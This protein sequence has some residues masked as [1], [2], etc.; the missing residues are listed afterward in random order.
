MTASPSLSIA[1][2]G[3]RLHGR[4]GLKWEYVRPSVCDRV[5]PPS[6]AAWIEISNLVGGSCAVTSPPSRAAWIEIQTLQ[7]RLWSYASPPSR[8]AWIEMKVCRSSAH[9][10]K[11]RRLH[12]RRGLKWQ[13]R[14]LQGLRA[15]GRR[16]HGRRGLK[17]LLPV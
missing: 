3:R 2:T 15:N 14:P 13:L 16:L 8:A 7:R 11:S 1:R 5:S 17:F 10:C 12:G 4:R 9:A 6:R